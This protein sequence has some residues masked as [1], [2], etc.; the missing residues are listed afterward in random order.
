MILRNVQ[1]HFVTYKI[2]IIASYISVTTECI[3]ISSINGF[4]HEGKCE[5]QT[6]IIKFCYAA[7][8]ITNVISALAIY[9]SSFSDRSISW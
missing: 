7:Y 8:L 3:P 1:Y 5:H 9:I 4:K 2:F 6:T